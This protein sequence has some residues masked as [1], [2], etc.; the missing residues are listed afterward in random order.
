MWFKASGLF[1]RHCVVL[2]KTTCIFVCFHG[3][4]PRFMSLR[5]IFGSR[6]IIIFQISPIFCGPPWLRGGC[7]GRLYETRAGR[8]QGREH[9]GTWGVTSVERDF[10][11][12]VCLPSTAGFLWLPSKSAQAFAEPGEETRPFRAD[13]VPELPGDRVGWGGGGREPAPTPTGC[14]EHCE[15][16][17]REL[18]RS[19]P[20]SA[21][22]P[23]ASG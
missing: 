23:S 14:E 3:D 11:T 12:D 2:I 16:T 10:K 17:A 18:E 7:R 19:Q 4:F 1:Q 13:V 15:D 21:T 9:L 5:H 6:R 20:A 22:R 8:R